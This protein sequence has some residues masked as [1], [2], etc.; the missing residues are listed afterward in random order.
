MGWRT[1]AS[2]GVPA[3]LFVATAFIACSP[4]PS[5][6]DR[7]PVAADRTSDLGGP[8]SNSELTHTFGGILGRDDPLVHEFVITNPSDAVVH[9]AS[10]VATTP[11][12]SR[13]ESYSRSIQPHEAGVIRV[14]MRTGPVTTRRRVQFLVSTDSTIF[15]SLILDSRRGSVRPVGDSGGR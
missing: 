11:C 4:T 14:S 5:G 13:V 7:A 6:R 2:L 8:P 10:A 9:I 1:K 15:P 12:C 3:A